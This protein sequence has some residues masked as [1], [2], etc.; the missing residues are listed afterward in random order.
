MW[1]CVLACV[2]VCW[3]GR[4]LAHGVC[5]AA[6]RGLAAN[7]VRAWFAHI[8]LTPLR[9]V[10]YANTAPPLSQFA[11]HGPEVADLIRDVCRQVAGVRPH[12]EMPLVYA[13]AI[14]QVGQCPAS[15]ED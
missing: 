8:L 6:H 5:R 1:A 10:D 2:H 13:D 15:Q 3:L 4:L 9:S 14:K 12:G 11:R 7:L